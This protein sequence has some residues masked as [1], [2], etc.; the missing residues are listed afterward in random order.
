MLASPQRRL[1][2]LLIVFY[3]I[4]PM[5]RT[6]KIQRSRKVRLPH[7]ISGVASSRVI[8][9]ARKDH[10]WP[11]PQDHDNAKLASAQ[12]LL[13]AGFD[14][15]HC[16][17]EEMWRTRGVRYGNQRKMRAHMAL[18]SRRNDRKRDPNPILDADGDL[19]LPSRPLS[20]VRRR[21]TNWSK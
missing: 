2:R 19:E 18:I 17:D 3:I 7:K 10:Q 1:W 16:L 13:D 11:T 9:K 5:S 14:P 4:F 6:H 20:P 21:G 15:D 12:A 8:K